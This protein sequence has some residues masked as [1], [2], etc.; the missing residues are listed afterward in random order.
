MR[1]TDR[2]L[3]RRRAATCRRWRRSSPRAESRSTGLACEPRR[4][5][6]HVDDRRRRFEALAPWRLRAALAD[7]DA[8]TSAGI[9][10]DEPDSRGYRRRG[11]DVSPTSCRAWT[12]VGSVVRESRPR[13]TS[14]R[15]SRR[16][17]RHGTRAGSRSPSRR[18]ARRT[19]VRRSATEEGFDAAGR[20]R[21]ERR[22][23][24]H[25]ARV[26][27]PEWSTRSRGARRQRWR[28]ASAPAA[29]ASGS[30]IARSSSTSKW[31]F[32]LTPRVA[33]SGWS[34]RESTESA[35]HRQAATDRSVAGTNCRRL[36]AGRRRLPR[37]PDVHREELVR[38]RRSGRCT[39]DMKVSP[40]LL[41]EC[42][43]QAWPISPAWRGQERAGRRRA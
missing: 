17:A 8:G 32:S 29:A 20:R 11:P 40:L 14:G 1:G 24:Q 10:C 2:E 28:L 15:P 43:C 39:H 30:P 38:I 6:R 23:R 36:N 16:C 3:A 7:L 5:G 35:S 41:V 37:P 13:S 25:L 33:G 9:G 26:S 22:R 42:Q 4:R 12:A 27:E 19:R 31:Q 21:V 18:V 34:R